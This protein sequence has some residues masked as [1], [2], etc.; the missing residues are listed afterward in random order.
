M[1]GTEAIHNLELIL[2]CH[3]SAKAGGKIVTVNRG[4]T[5]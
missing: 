4:S 1:D 3:E 2:K 5:N